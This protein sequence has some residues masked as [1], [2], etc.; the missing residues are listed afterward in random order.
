MTA[1]LE[2]VAKVRRANGK[3][4]VFSQSWE[5]LEIAEL[6]IRQ[7]H[8]DEACLNLKEDVRGDVDLESDFR[9]H[10][11]RFVLLL[12]AGAFAM[13]LTLT[14]ADT[15]II[16]EPQLD[17]ATEIQ[18]EHRIWRPGQMADRVRIVKLYMAG[19]IEEQLVEEHKEHKSHAEA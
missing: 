1:L 10:E 19:T 18:I 15:C 16:V 17:V 3:C 4:L 12:T 11:R 14:M 13:G 2:E 5:L 8:S 9:L 6:L 7:E